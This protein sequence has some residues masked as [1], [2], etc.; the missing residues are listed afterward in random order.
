MCM[1]AYVNFSKDVLSF[2][3]DSLRFF[4]FLE[5]GPY[6]LD[7]PLSSFTVSHRFFEVVCL[8]VFPDF[9]VDPFYF[10]QQHVVQSLC[11]CVVPFF[12]WYL[13]RF[14]KMS[15]IQ[16]DDCQLFQYSFFP[17]FLAEK[18][19]VGLSTLPCIKAST[20]DYVIK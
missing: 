12:S 10:L 18:K 6:S 1:C 9:I 15:V 2:K 16:N 4:L 13:K 8:E 3:K 14:L 11:N 19:K 17:S 5:Q 20:D 7:I